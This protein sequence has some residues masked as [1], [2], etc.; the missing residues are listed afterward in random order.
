[1]PERFKKDGDSIWWGDTLTVLQ[2][3]GWTC[4][5]PNPTSDGLL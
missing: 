2:T 4:A 5:L 1:M 3:N